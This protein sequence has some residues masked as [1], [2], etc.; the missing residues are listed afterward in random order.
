MSLASYRKI[1]NILRLSGIKKTSI[2]ALRETKG[3]SPQ[4]RSKAIRFRLFLSIGDH[5]RALFYAH[6]LVKKKQDIGYYYLA[7]YKFLFGSY[8]E[9]VDLINRIKEYGNIPDAVYLKVQALLEE[10]KTE[11]A[12]KELENLARWS[13]RIKT[14]AVMADMVNS[15]NDFDRF[16]NNLLS[17]SKGG[18]VSTSRREVVD[19]ISRAALRAKLYE[20]AIKIWQDFFRFSSQE[21][22]GR[23]QQVMFLSQSAAE[24]ALRNL[25]DILAVKEIKIFLIS[26]T[27][28]GYHRDNKILTHDKDMDVGVWDDVKLSYVR[29]A[30]AT[31]GFFY[32]QPSRSPHVL[33]VKHVNGVP[34][35]IFI[36][37]RTLTDYWHAG[38]KVSW[39]NSPFEL[40]EV[41]AFGDKYFIPS[42]EDRYLTE[43]YG[44]W[45][46]PIK[47]FDSARDT[48][49][50]KILNNREMENHILKNSK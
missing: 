31:S 48:P 49:N 22:R 24:V 8:S 19:Y 36:H 10:G 50:A 47:Q 30:L 5:N 1:F 35:D 39:H 23:K 26:G 11:N 2:L 45:R 16:F 37:Y 43:N 15:E 29:R 38:V 6:S 44:N 46:V 20:R 18:L 25:R 33:R 3:L 17:S 7:L 41:E 40:K 14:W 34:I 42:D 4:Y 9:A 21:K 32:M 27:L 28:L 12:W 13:K